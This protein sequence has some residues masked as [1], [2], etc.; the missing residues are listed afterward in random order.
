MLAGKLTA[1][2]IQKFKKKQ[3]EDSIYHVQSV[4]QIGAL[5]PSDHCGVG[6]FN[7]LQL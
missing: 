3:K 6:E 7:V 5:T 4:Q 1:A 2:K